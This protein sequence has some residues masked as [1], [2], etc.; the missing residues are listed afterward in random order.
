MKLELS[1]EE[2]EV[3]ERALGTYLGELEM[4]LARTEKHEL[5][6]SLHHTN[7]I[8]EGIHRRLR[9]DSTGTRPNLPA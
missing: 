2:V 9:T 7:R 4:V 3:L 5:Q 8:L 6:T 1:A